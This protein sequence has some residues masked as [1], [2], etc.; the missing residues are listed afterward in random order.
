MTLNEPQLRASLVAQAVKDPPANAGDAGSAPGLE[1]DMETR[2][3]T[4]P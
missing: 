1:Q 3:S 2:S 4:L